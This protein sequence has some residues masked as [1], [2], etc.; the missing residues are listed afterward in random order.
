MDDFVAISP[1]FRG[2]VVADAVC[3]LLSGTFCT[4]SL[5]QQRSPDG[6]VRFASYCGHHHEAF[7]AFRT[8]EV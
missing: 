4:P 5:I 7:L 6:T 8:S 1:D 2:T 3:P